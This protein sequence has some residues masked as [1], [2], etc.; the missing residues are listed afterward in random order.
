MECIAVVTKDRLG[1]LADVSEL[2]AKHGINIDS[3]SAESS[4]GT[5]VVRLHTSKPA[6][7]RALLA[8]HGYPSVDSRAMVVRFTDKPG[9]LARASRLLSD[10]GINIANLYLLTQNG[11]EKV[12]AVETT[13][14][15]AARKILKDYI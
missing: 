4:S 6:E 5:A 13:D 9:E 10:R 12:F 15:D 8:K 7:A 2:L 11:S 3:L 14:N 1:L